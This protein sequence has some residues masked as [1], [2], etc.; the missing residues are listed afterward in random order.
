MCLFLV[1]EWNVLGT[2]GSMPPDFLYLSC[3][4]W[5]KLDWKSPKK[6]LLSKDL[7]FLFSIQ[8]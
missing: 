6:G 3:D 2:F 8:F 5:D 7:K 4:F 1:D